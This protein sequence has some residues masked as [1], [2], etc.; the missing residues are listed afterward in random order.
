MIKLAFIISALY[1]F[2]ACSLGSLDLSDNRKIVVEPNHIE[3]SGDIEPWDWK[4]LF[5]LI[6]IRSKDAN[7][8]K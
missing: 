8:T 4:Q 2:T 1:L 5:K 3:I 6:A 7:T